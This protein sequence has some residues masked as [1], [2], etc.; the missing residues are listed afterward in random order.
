MPR[1]DF[2]DV[3]KWQGA[4]DWP[5]VAKG[6]QVLGVIAKATEGSS[7]VDEEYAANRAG[8]LANGLL[9]ASYHYLHPGNAEAQMQHY[10]AVAQPISGERVVLDYEESSPRVDMATLEAAIDFLRLT[11]PDLQISVYGASMLTD[12]CAACAD[13]RFLNGTSLWA[14]RYS[15]NQPVVADPPWPYWTAW[16]YSD[17]G[18]VKGIDGDVD[19]NTFNGTR[20][21]CLDWFG[22]AGEPVPEP[23]PEL[24]AMLTTVEAYGFVVELAIDP[25]AGVAVAVNGLAWTPST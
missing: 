13:L 15:S 1:L 3:S 8:A 4:I 10:L 12:D 22:P 2:I 25:V 18:K 23:E 24:G 17:E 16:Q 5:A 6:G 19:L 21:A 20:D 9:F 11:R 14:A 7:H